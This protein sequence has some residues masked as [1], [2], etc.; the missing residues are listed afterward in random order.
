[1]KKP[2][3]F[4]D[5]YGRVVGDE[6]VAEREAPGVTFGTPVVEAEVVEEEVVVEDIPED[7][8]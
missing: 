3:Q 1:M 4:S 7:D 6:E 5:K 2:S 8:E